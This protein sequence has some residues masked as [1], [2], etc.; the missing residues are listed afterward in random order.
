MK[1]PS[2]LFMCKL[3]FVQKNVTTTF[4]MQWNR[5][6]VLIIIWDVL[7]TQYFVHSISALF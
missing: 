5:S 6:H 2:Y 3:R 7:L 1:P 4:F